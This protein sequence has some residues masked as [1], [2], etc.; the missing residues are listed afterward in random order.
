MRSGPISLVFERTVDVEPGGELVPFYHFGIK[1]VRG[2]RVGHLNF[3][4]GDT[5]HIRQC[6][7][8]IGYEVFPGYRGNSYAY[9]ACNAIRPFVQVFYDRVILTSDPQ[10]PSSI[11]TIEKLNARFLDELTVPRHDHSYKSG[12]RRK[13]RYEWEP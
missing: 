11:R 8:H 5:N 4:I 13:R 7:G 12:S 2:T 10:N 1:D 9:I 3:R 6:A